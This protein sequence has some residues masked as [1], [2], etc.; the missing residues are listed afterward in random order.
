MRLSLNLFKISEELKRLNPKWHLPD[1]REE[2]EEIKRQAF[3]SKLDWKKLLEAFQNGKIVTLDDS[4]W[5]KM[6]NTDS[7]DPNLTLNEIK[8]WKTKDVESIIEAFQTGKS[9]PVPMV[10]IHQNIPIC[11]AGNTR[12]S[13]SK[14]LNIH[15]EVLVAVL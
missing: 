9:L 5:N 8:T 15:P 11:V 3:E 2:L 6:E 12:L 14:V 1:L 10:L 7:N 13:I 4:T